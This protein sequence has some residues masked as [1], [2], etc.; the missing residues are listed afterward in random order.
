MAEDILVLSRSDE[1]NYRALCNFFQGRKVR[2]TQ[3]RRTSD[4]ISMARKMELLHVQDYC[5]AHC[6]K[7]FVRKNG[8]L[9]DVTADH[10]IQYCYGGEAN[11]HNIALVHYQCNRFREANYN[12]DIIEKHFGP[13]DTNMI[14]YVPVVYFEPR[15]NNITQKKKNN[16]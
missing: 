16:G 8:K 1:L 10:I 5:C 2:R 14:D 3:S 4:I 9:Y 6:G 13:I 15:M 12:I 7:E 11:K